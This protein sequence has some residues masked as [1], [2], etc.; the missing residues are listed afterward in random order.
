MCV[1]LSHEETQVSS[2]P[3]L[4]AAVSSDEDPSNQCQEEGKERVMEERVEELERRME[5]GVEE[6]E[7]RVEEGVEKTERRVEEGMK[8]DGTWHLCRHCEMAF[9]DQLTHR[10]HMG[11]HGFQHPFQC[12]SCG[13]KCLDAFDFML[14]L[15]CKAHN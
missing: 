13:Q 15:M 6:M 4:G 14:H 8:V 3:D 11:Y 1:P 7:K 5:E 9:A 2:C 10:L 12:N